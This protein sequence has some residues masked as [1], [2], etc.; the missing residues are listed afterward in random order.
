[1]TTRR[2][3]TTHTRGRPTRYKDITTRSRL[4][5]EFLAWLDTVPEVANLWAYESEAFASSEGSY[6][7][8]VVIRN[9]TN[10]LRELPLCIE[11]KPSNADFIAA[12]QRM[13]I[14]L[15]SE[16]YAV[17]RVYAGTWMGGRYSFR[18][19]EQCDPFKPCGVD[20]CQRRS[21]IDW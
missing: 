8:D 20:G 6:L 3:M 19:V 18:K 12:L 15:D 14:I 1:M 16:E 5:A 4:E 11:L 7:P 2:T 9:E 17:L 21:R 10:G 13:H